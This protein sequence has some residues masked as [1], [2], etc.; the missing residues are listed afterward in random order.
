VGAVALHAAVPFQLSRL[1]RARPASTSPVVRGAGLVT[2]A[3]GGALMGWAFA[4]HCQRAPQG[5]PLESGLTP[6]YLLRQGP[7]RLI[8]NPIY[9]GEAIAWAGWGL[10][11]ACPAVWAGA[12]IVCTGLATTVRW[13]ERRLLQRFGEDYRAYLAEVPRWVPGSVSCRRVRGRAGSVLNNALATRQSVA[14]K[15]RQ[16]L[17]RGW[18]LRFD[19]GGRRDGA[20]PAGMPASSPFRKDADVASGPAR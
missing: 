13:E 8:R 11:Y 14:G 15:R 4:A 17:S 3:A 2:V 18:P 20:R 6:G 12:A 19:G 9:A 1:S 5:W 16:S 7:Y 10:V